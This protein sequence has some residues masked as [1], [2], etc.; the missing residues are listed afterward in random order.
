M[1]PA[2]FWIRAVA[3]TAAVS[4]ATAAVGSMADKL[5]R[6]GIE[7]SWVGQISRGIEAITPEIEHRDNEVEE[8]TRP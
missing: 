2:Y 8:L 5:F 1:R 7:K 3:I 6:R 4:A